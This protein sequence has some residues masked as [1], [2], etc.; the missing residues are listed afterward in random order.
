[1]RRQV[2]RL[3]PIVVALAAL[4][5]QPAHAGTATGSFS[6]SATVISACTVSGSALSFGTTVNPL[7]TAVPLYAQSQLSV[8]CTNTTPYAVALNAGTNAGGASNFSARAMKNGSNSIGYQLYSD[9]G[10][11]TVWG[12]GTNSSSTVS[13]TGS[14]ST[15]TLNIYGSV[16][17]LAGAVPG[18][19]TDTVTVTVSY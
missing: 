1:M 16:P 4:A 2:S 8:Q 14:G 11:S 18:S 6:V 12:D 15:Q 7:S 13:G 19:Y 5:G 3:L 10:H 9:T 17:S